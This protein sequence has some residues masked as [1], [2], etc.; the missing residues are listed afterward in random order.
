M[1]CIICQDSGIEPLQD[2]TRCKCKYKCHT[3]C[4]ID[5]VH[6]KNKITCP[7]CRKDITF[8]SVPK[9]VSNQVQRVQSPIIQATAPYTSE[10]QGQ[11][12]SYQEFV[13]IIYQYNSAQNTIIQVRPITQQVTQVTP[14]TVCQ[15]VVKV[16]IG[17]C[18]LAVIITLFSVYLG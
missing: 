15:K 9:S 5:Y 17:L 2:N 18:I 3:S 12:I 10:Q 6:S 11:Q 16:I 7:L 1:N 4:W 13:D 14:Q 8:N